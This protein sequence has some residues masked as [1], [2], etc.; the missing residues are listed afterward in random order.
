MP[1]VQPRTP[2]V[3]Q[4]L[5]IFPSRELAQGGGAALLALLL[6]ARDVFGVGSSIPREI[7]LEAIV[8]PAEKRA[9]GVLDERKALLARLDRGVGMSDD[10]G[11]DQNAAARGKPNDEVVFPADEVA[12][13]VGVEVTERA[14]EAHPVGLVV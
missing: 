13:L 5:R 12:A 7:R 4:H 6:S 10:G 14:D 11:G 8:H 9:R 3:V 1:N 2:R